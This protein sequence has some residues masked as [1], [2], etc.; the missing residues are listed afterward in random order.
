MNP[1]PQC[2][3]RFDDWCDYIIFEQD[4]AYKIYG[5]IALG[6]IVIVAGFFLLLKKIQ[7][8]PQVTLI[9]YCEK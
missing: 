6:A 5:I 1:Y 9:D 2:E 8:T 7:K 4:P 3:I